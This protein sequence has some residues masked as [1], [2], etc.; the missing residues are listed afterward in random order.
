MSALVVIGEDPVTLDGFIDGSSNLQLRHN[1]SH[2][3][4]YGQTLHARHD[5]LRSPSGLVRI[6]LMDFSHGG[7]TWQM[8]ASHLSGANTV[9]WSRGTDHAYY[10]FGP[11]SSELKVSTSTTSDASPPPQRTVWIKTMPTDGL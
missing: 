10:D 6:K 7:A 5:D 1:L 9:Y 2:L 4:N 11:M 3:A 8:N